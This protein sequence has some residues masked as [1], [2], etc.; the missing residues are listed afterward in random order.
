MILPQVWQYKLPGVGAGAEGVVFR[1][2]MVWAGEVESRGDSTGGRDGGGRVERR[3]KGT[4][5]RIGKGVDAQRILTLVV[6][7][8]GIYI[9]A[10]S[11]RFES[12]DFVYFY[13]FHNA[14]II[15]LYSCDSLQH[16][17]L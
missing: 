14:V 4:L 11:L 17:L 2:D 15:I 5:L 9:L 3:E 13:S 1:V 16:W 6:G 10:H 12:H 8:S 7:V